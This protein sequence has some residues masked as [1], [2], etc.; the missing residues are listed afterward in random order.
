[1]TE[2]SIVRG[3]EEKEG[4][5]LSLYDGEKIERKFLRFQNYFYVRSDE[6][7]IHKESFEYQWSKITDQ[8]HMNAKN[9]DA[10]GPRVVEYTKIL[11]HNNWMRTKIRSWFEDR[12]IK[13]F[14]ADVKATKRFLIDRH[15]VGLN[16][17][18][19]NVLFFDI[20][21]DD[22]KPLRKDDRGSVI[23]QGPVLSF[24]GVNDKDELFMFVNEGD[25]PEDGERALLVKISEA[26]SKHCIVSGWNSSN[27]DCPYLKQRMALHGVDCSWEYLN[28]LDY[29]DL[30]RKNYRQ[31]LPSYKLNNVA[32]RIIGE[33]KLD[34][35]KGN[36]AVY[37]AWKDNREHFLAYNKQDV[38]L[39]VK[40]DKSLQFISLHKAI[41]EQAHCYIYETMQNSLSM[42][43]ML[44]IRYKK[45]GI[46]MPSKP[47]QVE[48]QINESKGRIGGGYTT[49]FEPGVHEQVEVFDFKCVDENAIVTTAK[50]FIKAKD[51]QIGDEVLTDARMCKVSN[52]V[53]TTH[54]SYVKIKVDTGDELCVSL[55]HRLPTADGKLKQGRE[56]QKG[57]NLIVNVRCLPEKNGDGFKQLCFLAGAWFAEGGVVSGRADNPYIYRV[58]FSLHKKEQEFAK[59]ISSIINENTDAKI[60]TVYRK[61]TDGMKLVVDSKEFFKFFTTFMEK[62]LPSSLMNEENARAFLQAFFE[63]DG[64][65]NICRETVELNQCH[66]KKERLM[67]AHYLLRALGIQSRTNQY[68]STNQTEKSFKTWRLEVRDVEGFE[69][70]AG[71]FLKERTFEYERNLR[72]KGKIV[73]VE[74]VHERMKMVDLTIEGHPYFIVNNILSH[75]SFYPSTI[76][77]WNLSPETLLAQEQEGCIITPDDTNDDTGGERHHPHRYYL[78]EKGI[79]PQTV[80][81]LVDERDKTKYAMKEFISSDPDKYRK[82]YLHQYALKV[83]SNS[84]YGILS[85]SRARYY[86]FEL[87]DSVTTCCRALI[88]SLN[89]YIEANSGVVIGGDTDSSFVKFPPG[90][91]MKIVDKMIAD[92]LD[93]WMVQ[94]KTDGHCQ[95][96]EHEKTVAPMLFLKKK[97]YAYLCEAEKSEKNPHGLTVKGLAGKKS[98]ANPLAG[99][100]QKEYVLDVL[101][102]RFDKQKWQ[103]FLDKE[104][105]RCIAGE[106]ELKEILMSKAVSKNP[107]D[108]GGPVIDKKTRQPKIKKDGSIQIRPIPAHVK[109]ALRMLDQGELVDIGTKIRYV[110]VDTK[111]INGLSQSEYEAHSAAGGTYDAKYY[112]EKI[113][114]PLFSVML[115]AN[116]ERYMID[117]STLHVPK[118]LIAKIAKEQDT[119][120]EEDD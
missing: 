36:G 22:R 15:E 27:F 3:Y 46:I 53:F 98:D 17:H 48:V 40:M 63:G 13:T 74:H 59:K 115:R 79:V 72:K 24:V 83:L 8:V 68:T 95:V 51:V 54:K 64:S 111:P 42:D 19:Q 25:D 106:L 71:F 5:V 14:E 109:I 6:F 28:E 18:L 47:T 39:I 29:L 11:L 94:W 113:I 93:E 105:A 49:C 104:Y 55:D 77:T 87:G 30:F 52:K 32:K 58:T 107:S 101:L 73:S 4:I 75:N 92:Y 89:K 84:I 103:E 65:Y 85:F 57:D 90:S 96:F 82:M 70:Q 80:R 78:R 108:Y 91:D 2:H 26:I 60:K 7:E 16:S 114:T 119:D 35:A 1:M 69:K 116:D 67:L 110:V 56:L 88:K 86:S 44:L 31:S 61:N 62:T 20:E 41:A 21:T 118:K 10:N 12:S 97:N 120:E 76:E 23:A 66:K 34:Q 37:R 45:A 102:N 38:D 100:L 112:W 117:Y 43:V 9:C 99:K 33:E 50:G 81:E